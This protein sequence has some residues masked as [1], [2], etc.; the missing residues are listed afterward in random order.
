[1]IFMNEYSSY[2]NEFINRSI[3]MTDAL[4]LGYT[5]LCLWYIC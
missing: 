4:V 1:M 5:N 2:A 3:L